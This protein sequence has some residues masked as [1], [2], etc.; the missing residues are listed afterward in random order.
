MDH[1]TPTDPHL[2]PQEHVIDTFD[3]HHPY[4]RV[5]SCATIIAELVIKHLKGPDHADH[6]KFNSLLILLFGAILV[7]NKNLEKKMDEDDPKQRD[8]AVY[9]Y[10]KDNVTHNKWKKYVKELNDEKTVTTGMSAYD[11][12]CRDLKFLWK[13]ASPS[14]EDRIAVP[15]I[16]ISA[17]AFLEWTKFKNG[18]VEGDI[19]LFMKTHR[20]ECNLIIIM[21]TDETLKQGLKREKKKAKK[22]A[23][24]VAAGGGDSNGE[25]EDESEDEPPKEVV[26][27]L[28][29]IPKDPK[30]TLV[31]EFIDAL[32]PSEGD[33]PELGISQELNILE[34]WNARGV[35]VYKDP[36]GLSRKD[37]LP[38]LESKLN[39]EA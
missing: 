2:I 32:K 10:I 36:A 20:K 34:V 39:P 30:S 19:Q 11:L 27:D 28:G 3:H 1:N 35:L 16:P 26:R 9:R 15:R 5:G 14:R 22:S 6:D 38:K 37:I 12:L 31:N 8:A 33:K 24:S 7:D 4:E 23:K 13:N 25:T 29:F 18:S 21:G 17:K